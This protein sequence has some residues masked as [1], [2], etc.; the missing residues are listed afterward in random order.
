MS[1]PVTEAVN[2]KKTK[3]IL[4]VSGLSV[5]YPG[6]DGSGTVAI[7]GISFAITPG[8]FV[9]IIGP[10]G[11]GKSTLLH[12]LGGLQQATTGSVLFDGEPFTRPNPKHAAFVFQDYSLFPWKNVVDNAA[13]GLRFA[14]VPKRQRR[15][16]AMK[17]LEAVGLSDRALSLP[18]EL[19]GGMQQRVAVG[20]AL[21]MDPQVLLMDEPFGALDEQ[22]RRSLGIELS[23]TLTRLGKTLIMVTHSLDEAIFWADRVIVMSRSPGR[24]SEVIEVREPRPRMPEFIKGTEFDELRAHL[25]DLL[26]VTTASADPVG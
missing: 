21:T 5:R 9:S 16:L 17:Q 18:E 4:E 11:C 6:S 22:T 23:S 7:E 20:R 15:A 2:S 1:V 3:P 19:S 10:S 12:C 14:R 26:G 8:E 25:F 13:A 24:I